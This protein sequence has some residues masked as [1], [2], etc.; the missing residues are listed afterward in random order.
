[1]IFGFMF[2]LVKDQIEITHEYKYL[3]IDFYAHYYFQSFSKR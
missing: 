3:G 1:M 2:D